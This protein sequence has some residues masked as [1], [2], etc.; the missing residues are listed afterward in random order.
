MSQQALSVS[1]NGATGQFVGSAAAIQA[2]MASAM[3]ERQQQ[4]FISPTAAATRAIYGTGQPEQT[5]SARGR[6]ELRRPQ[7]IPDGQRRS[8]HAE[9]VQAERG[10][11]ALP[12]TE[13]TTPQRAARVEDLSSESVELQLLRNRL[14]EVKL[15]NKLFDE[16]EALSAR[17][18]CH[19]VAAAR[20]PP[21]ENAHPKTGVNACAL[22]D[23]VRGRQ[24]RRFYSLLWADFSARDAISGAEYY[25]T[26]VPQPGDGPAR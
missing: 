23:E 15:W 10:T 22:A 3:H 4:L 2:Q 16:Q 20:S 7:R 5:P 9:L 19:L 11:G 21:K 1:V 18:Q 13:R 6:G 14:R 17:K 8:A 12:S 25:S 26:V 24:R